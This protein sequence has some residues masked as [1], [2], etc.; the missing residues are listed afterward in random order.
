MRKAGRLP[1]Y[2]VMQA[3]HFDFQMTGCFAFRELEISSG[4]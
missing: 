4:G 1:E 3:E 2:I